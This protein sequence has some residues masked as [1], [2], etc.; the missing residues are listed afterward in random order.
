MKIVDEQLNSADDKKVRAFFQKH[1]AQIY[2]AWEAKI[3]KVFKNYLPWKDMDDDDIEDC[4][5][6]WWFEVVEQGWEPP[7]IAIGLH[8]VDSDEIGLIGDQIIEEIARQLG[9]PYEEV[10]VL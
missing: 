5:T 6:A 10:F 2:R 8:G 9:I 4:R 3:K 7:I 1:H